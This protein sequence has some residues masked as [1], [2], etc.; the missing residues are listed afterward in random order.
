[1][2]FD[3]F[4]SFAGHTIP[5]LGTQIDDFLAEHAPR[6]DQLFTILIGH[7]DF[8]LHGEPSVVHSSIK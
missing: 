4:D 8:A 2:V 7:N 1:M 3:C 6:D 5:R